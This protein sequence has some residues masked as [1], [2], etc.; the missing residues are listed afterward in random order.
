MLGKVFEARGLANRSVRDP[1]QAPVGCRAQ[2]QSLQR[3][4]PIAEGEHLLTGQRHAHRALQF[5]RGHDGEWQLILRAQARAE[6]TADIGRENPDLLFLEAED[7]L[8]VGLTVLRPLSLVMNVQAAIGLVQHRAGVRLHRIVMFN[9]GAVIQIQADSRTGELGLK[10]PTGLGQFG[11]RGMR[12]FLRRQQ[13]GLMGF[14][15][16]FDHHQGTGMARQF[17]VV[18]HHQRKWL[19]TVEHP[20]VVQRTKR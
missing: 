16:V 5:E 11:G 7:F 4:R 9:R 17:K 6:R 14:A 15:F 1:Q 10:I 20:V 12:F 18:R 8:H 13:I 3:A 2:L 19:A